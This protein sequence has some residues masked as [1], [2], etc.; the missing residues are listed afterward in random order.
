MKNT[1]CCSLFLSFFFLPA[2]GQKK[3]EYIT[4]DWPGEYNWKILKKEDDQNKQITIII[5]GKETA[6]TASILGFLTAYKGVKIANTDDISKD[7]K[8]RLDTGS[9]LTVLDK[10]QTTKS[11]WIIFKVETPATNKYPEPES[12]LYYVVQGQ[13]ALYEN[14]VAIKQPFLT[15]EFVNKWIAIFKTSRLKI[16]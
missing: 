16:E 4:I 7:Y 13:Y 8:S 9:T 1:I 11:L 3:T 14:Y 12:D 15:P 6:S 10:E 5:P 2:T